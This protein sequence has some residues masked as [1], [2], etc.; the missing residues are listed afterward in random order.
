[1]SKSR[2][3]LVF[4]SRL[5]G[6]GVD[7][8]AIRLALIAAP[9]R[10][11]RQYTDGVLKAGQQRLGLWRA[12]AAA[13]QGPSGEALL[14]GVRGALAN[15][16]DTPAALRIVDEWCE[17]AVAGSGADPTAPALMATTVDTLL[18]IALN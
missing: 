3:N 8:M 17:L 15:D 1:M 13:E 4:V 7:P 9:Y 18:G 14:A 10:Q 11:D 2:G 12:G 6:D 16:L 5:R